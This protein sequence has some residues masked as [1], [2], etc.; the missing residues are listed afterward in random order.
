MEEVKSKLKIE[1]PSYNCH[2][3]IYR[4]LHSLTDELEV[5]LK[6]GI[7]IISRWSMTIDMYKSIPLYWQITTLNESKFKA[8]DLYYQ[9]SIQILFKQKFINQW[10]DL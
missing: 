3:E 9:K 7:L 10:E 1:N 6:K 8:A 2:L 5:V 4:A